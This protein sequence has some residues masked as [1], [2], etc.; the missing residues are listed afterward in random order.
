MEVVSYPHL[1]AELSRAYIA[2]YT[3][4]T[5]AGALRKRIINAASM[6]G[7]EGE[8]EREAVNYAFVDPRLITSPLHVKTAVLQAVMAQAQGALRTKTVHSEVLW[9]LN[10]SNNISEAIRRYGVSEACTALLVVR[11]D[12]SALEPADVE[13]KMGAAVQG[14][15]VP[16]TQLGRL[17]DWVAVKKCHK[18]NN[19]LALKVCG[20][21]G[22]RE[23]AVIDNIV[24][25]S[26]AMKSVMG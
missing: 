23:R 9:A 11:V 12:G 8:D 13:R 5:N 15:L 26:V 16:L 21:D 20:Q 25:S 10:P 1:P 2:L 19:E 18:L 24:V 17:T 7:R 22:E 4:V 14:Q 3:S 6:Q